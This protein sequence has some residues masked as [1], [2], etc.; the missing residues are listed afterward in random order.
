MRLFIAIDLPQ[1]VKDMVRAFEKELSIF[2]DLRFVR[3]EHMHITLSFFGEVADADVEAL[4]EKLHKI[5]FDP[6]TLKTLGYGF[7]PTSK[8]IRI[9]WIGLERNEEFFR[10]QESLRELYRQKEK[11]MPHIT[12]AR[13]KDIMIREIHQL[14]EEVKKVKYE[15]VTFPVDRFILYSSE[16]TCQKS[17]LCKLRVSTRRQQAISEHAQELHDAGKR[18]QFLTPQGPIHKVIEEYRAGNPAETLIT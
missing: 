15:E 3:P 10:L 6:F 11:F 17:P 18:S 4:R 1:A 9:V 12:L 2:K 7:F 8:R 5:R 16:L 14:N 13:A